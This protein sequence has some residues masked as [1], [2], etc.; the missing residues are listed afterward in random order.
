MATPAP[1]SP[2]SPSSTASKACFAIAAYPI[3]QIANNATFV[4]TALLLIYGEL[5]TQQKLEQFRSLLTEHEMLHEGLRQ[6]FDGFPNNGDP[7][8]ILS[9]MINAMSCY[10]PDVLDPEDDS[11]F[12]IG[13]RPTDV[14]GAHHRRGRL[15]SRPSASR[16]SIPEPELGYCRTSCT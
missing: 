16:S 5:P 14:Q 9:A 2:P 6:A 11:T 1:A 7:M 4:E 3:E 10:N 8:A 15:Q 13:R 12:E